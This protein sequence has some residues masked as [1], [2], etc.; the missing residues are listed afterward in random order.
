[1]V[2]VGSRHFHPQPLLHVFF[3]RVCQKSEKCCRGQPGCP[4]ICEIA[5]TDVWAVCQNPWNGRHPNPAFIGCSQAKMVVAETCLYVL[6]GATYPTCFKTG[7]ME[8]PND[9]QP[10]LHWPPWSRDS[11]YILVAISLIV[12][13][14]LIPSTSNTPKWLR[15]LATIVTSS[16]V[17]RPFLM[18]LAGVYRKHIWECVSLWSW[19]W[20]STLSMLGVC[21]R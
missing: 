19:F 13:D 10:L 4:S 18:S 5:P 6:F 21:L 11:L 16:Y 2:S 20:V 3:P 9:H 17:W 15:C 1:M 7:R 8:N 12:P 14:V